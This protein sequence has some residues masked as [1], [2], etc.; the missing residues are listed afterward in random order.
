MQ[1]EQKSILP[2]L[3]KYFWLFGKS[4]GLPKH[5]LLTISFLFSLR[6]LYND[7]SETHYEWKVLIKFLVGR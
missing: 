1:E 3:Q 2:V 7:R 6:H 5:I 4:G